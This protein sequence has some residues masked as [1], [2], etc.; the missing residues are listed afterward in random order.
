MLGTCCIGMSRPES[1]LSEQ[2]TQVL[3]LLNMRMNF[4]RLPA[5][6]YLFTDSRRSTET[7]HL[8]K[9]YAAAVAAASIIRTDDRFADD[10]KVRTRGTHID[11]FM[12]ARKYR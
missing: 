12:S 7:P 3:N 2:Y 6:L 1:A 10:C 8:Q 4:D 9:V 5:L 11:K